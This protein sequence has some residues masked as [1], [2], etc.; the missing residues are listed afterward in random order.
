[1]INGSFR[2]TRT[3]RETTMR[4]TL[5]SLERRQISLMYFKQTSS[6]K[7]VATEIFIGREVQFHLWFDPTQDFHN[8][9]VLWN[10]TEIIFF[11]DDI[12]IRRYPRQSDATFP[13]RPMWVYGSIWDASSWATEEG[14]YKADYRYQPF[15][16]RYQ[17]FKLG[18]CTAD[19]SASCHPPSG[20][21]LGPTGLSQ[22]QILAM[23]W[24]KSNYKAYDYCQDPR[25][26]HSLTPEC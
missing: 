15:I 10:P 19:G 26:D 5:S 14:K 2:T 25:R 11:V 18:G 22:Q 17:T 8:Y 1:M 3:I 24:V 12:P 20:S 6:L 21:P 16:G 4:L 23:E 13:I 9:A 7:E